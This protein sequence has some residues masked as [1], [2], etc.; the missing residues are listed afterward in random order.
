MTLNHWKK[1]EGHWFFSGYKVNVMLILSESCSPG[2]DIFMVCLQTAELKRETGRLHT[3]G[4]S[5]TGEG[6]P[7]SDYTT[8]AFTFLARFRSDAFSDSGKLT[9][10]QECRGASKQ[11][12]KKKIY[13]SCSPE[14]MKQ[15]GKGPNA[16]GKCIGNA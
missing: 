4:S 9:H 15:L 12:Q 10:F 13:L 5:V 6:L 8:C 3:K 7:G 14:Q 1:E 2:P 16:V 11:S